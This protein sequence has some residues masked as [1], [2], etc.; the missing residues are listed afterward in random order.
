MNDLL[1]IAG[2]GRSGTTW[3]LDAVAEANQLRTKFEPL[4]PDER[5][6]LVEYLKTL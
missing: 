4:G 5:W 2:S 3:V 6:Q 1:I